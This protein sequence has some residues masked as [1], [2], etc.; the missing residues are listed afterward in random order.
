MIE[1]P[2]AGRVLFLLLQAGDEVQQKIFEN[3]K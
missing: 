3:L 1:N 2:A